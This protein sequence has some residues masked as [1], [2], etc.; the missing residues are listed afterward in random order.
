MVHFENLSTRMIEAN[1][2]THN[3]QGAFG[4]LGRKFTRRGKT[5]AELK[6]SP[7]FTEAHSSYR[8]IGV[9]VGLPLLS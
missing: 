6:G 9:P 3:Q 7:A 1:A 5:E 8:Q 2:R 4:N